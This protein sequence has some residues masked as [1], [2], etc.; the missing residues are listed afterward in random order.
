[1]EY[2][3]KEQ[4]DIWEKKLHQYEQKKAVLRNRID[5]NES[6][7]QQID[8]IPVGNPKVDR[9]YRYLASLY[10]QFA[11]LPAKIRHCKDNIQTLKCEL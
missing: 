9:F 2:N 8:K 11:A 3:I 10:T 6:L 7:R 4:I 1:M 5:K